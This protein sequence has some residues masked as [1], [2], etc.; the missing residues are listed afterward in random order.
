MGY[1]AVLYLI[2]Y[3]EIVQHTK[4]AALYLWD[5]VGA[6]LFFFTLYGNDTCLAVL[7]ESIAISGFSYL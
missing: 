7:V 2:L 4:S 5:S 6:A 3:N 1:H